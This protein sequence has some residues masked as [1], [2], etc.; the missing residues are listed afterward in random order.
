MNTKHIYDLTF[1][2]C[3]ALDQN[4][5]VVNM[6][7]VMSVISTL[8]GTTITKEQLEATRLAKYINH[9]RRRLTKDKHLA[10]RAKSLL[11]KWRKMVG[12]QQQQQ[13]IIETATTTSSAALPCISGLNTTLYQQ[14]RLRSQSISPAASSMHLDTMQQLSNSNSSQAIIAP[15]PASAIVE[16]MP[17][18][19]NVA[20]VSLASLSAGSTNVHVPINNKK[21]GEMELAKAESTPA[22]VVPT[23]DRKQLTSFENVLSGFGVTENSNIG[24]TS[25]KLNQL[26]QQRLVLPETFIIDQSSNSNS[27]TSLILPSNSGPAKDTPIVIDIQDSNSGSNLVTS[28]PTISIVSNRIPPTGFNKTNPFKLTSS[29]GMTISPSPSSSKPKKLKKEK[30]RKDKVDH[31]EAENVCELKNA[32]ALLDDTSSNHQRRNHPGGNVEKFPSFVNEEKSRLAYPEI[33]SLLDNSSMTSMFPPDGSTILAD[34]HKV[35][36][37]TSSHTSFNLST[38]DLTFTGKFKQGNSAPP[39]G[40]SNDIIGYNTNRPTVSPKIAIVNNFLQTVPTA[41]K[42][43]PFRDDG[44]NSN[45]S[46]SNSQTSQMDLID[47]VSSDKIL[48]AFQ[49]QRKQDNSNSQ[50]KSVG[51]INSGNPQ[52]FSSS[53]FSS[54]KLQPSSKME[55]TIFAGSNA[56]IALEKKLPRKRGRKKGSKGVDF[57]IAKETSLSSQ[58]LMTSLGSGSKKVKTTKELYAEMQNRK[59]GIM[60]TSSPTLAGWAA[61][62]NQ[63]QTSR[64]TS[65]CSEPS[66]QSPHTFDACSTNATMSTVATRSTPEKYLTNANAVEGET[67]SDTVTSEP[68]RDSSVIPKHIKRSLSIESNSNSQLTSS[69]KGNA[70][71]PF[72]T[73]MQSSDTSSQIAAIEKQ[74]LEILKKLPPVPN[75]T[76]TELKRTT[77]LIPCT[78]KITE[79]SPEKNNLQ[80]SAK[81]QKIEICAATG[82]LEQNNVKHDP[83]EQTDDKSIIKLDAVSRNVVIGG[84]TEL[85][86]NSPAT[87]PPPLARMKPKKSIFDLDFDDDDDPLHTLKAEAAAASLKKGIMQENLKIEVESESHINNLHFEQIQP[88][89]PVYNKMAIEQAASQTMREE[90]PMLLFPTYEVEEDPLCIAKQRFDIQT[91][92]ITKFHID[93]LHNCFIPNVNGNWDNSNNT[94]ARNMTLDKVTAAADAKTEYVITDGC[95][96][97]PRY[98]SL[99]MERIR[100]DLSHISFTRNS[101][102]KKTVTAMEQWYIIPFLGVARSLLT[103]NKR[104]SHNHKTCHKTKVTTLKISE[105]ENIGNAEP[106][107]KANKRTEEYKTDKQRICISV[108]RNDDRTDL[109]PDTEAITSKDICDESTNLDAR[110]SVIK[111]FDVETCAIVGKNNNNVTLKD[112]TIDVIGHGTDLFL[113]HSNELSESA[114]NGQNL[115]AIADHLGYSSKSAVKISLSP[116]TLSLSNNN[117]RQYS[118]ELGSASD[119]ISDTSCRPVR[120]L[121]H[122]N[123]LQ[124][125][126]KENDISSA[127]VEENISSRRSSISSNSSLLQTQQSINLKL[128]RQFQEQKLLDIS[129]ERKRRRKKF[130][131]RYSADNKDGDDIGPDNKQP[132]I[133]RIKIA[134]SGDVATQMQISGGSNVNSTD[135]ENED[136]SADTLHDGDGN[137]EIVVNDRALLVDGAGEDGESIKSAS[138]HVSTCNQFTLVSVGDEF[139]ANSA[140]NNYTDE[141]EVDYADY[142]DPDVDADVEF[143]EYEDGEDSTGDFHEVVTRDI[144][145]PSTGNNHILLTIKKTPSKTNSPSNSISTMSP[146]IINNNT[147]SSHALGI[148]MQPMICNTSVNTS[149]SVGGIVM[150]TSIVKNLE[151]E[152]STPPFEASVTLTSSVKEILSHNQVAMG[153]TNDMPNVGR[154]STK[155]SFEFDDTESLTSV[156]SLDFPQSAANYFHKKCRKYRRRRKIRK[157]D[158]GAMSSSKAIK[159]HRELFFPYELIISDHDDAKTSLLNIS[160]C[161]SSCVEDSEYDDNE[162]VTKDSNWGKK[163][164]YPLQTHSKIDI[165]LETDNIESWETRSDISVRQQRKRSSS[166]SSCSTYSSSIYELFMANQANS[167]KSCSGY[168]FTDHLIESAKI[169][170]KNYDED[171]VNELKKKDKIEVNEVTSEPSPTVNISNSNEQNSHATSDNADKNIEDNI[172]EELPLAN[173]WLLHSFNN[174]YYTVDKLDTQTHDE[175]MNNDDKDS[176]MIFDNVV[177]GPA[178]VDAAQQ[179]EQ[180]LLNKN[181]V[182]CY[183]NLYNKNSNNINFIR[184]YINDASL[185]THVNRNKQSASCNEVDQR[186]EENYLNNDEYDVNTDRCVSIDDTKSLIIGEDDNRNGINLASTQTENN[187]AYKADISFNMSCENYGKTAQEMLPY[188]EYRTGLRAVDEDVDDDDGNNCARIQQFKEWHQV[189][190]LRSYN[191][192]LLTVL[193]YVVLD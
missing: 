128:R 46:N 1:R 166:I 89:Q 36:L 109:I 168:D 3:Q 121:C 85:K 68:S 187:A 5:D 71:S 119:L 32:T 175:R 144:S 75:I 159:L 152:E 136:E 66:L 77:G 184:Y 143:N 21:L 99:V 33:L 130:N 178:V 139:D 185:E 81:N 22:S 18:I 115:L 137:E 97:A 87:S 35:N 83:L 8:E 53:V 7:A 72:M 160:S 10:L 169:K 111:P 15:I 24:I 153:I 82:V 27:E 186:Q 173:N 146:I 192:E 182:N 118:S 61:P 120:N 84:T 107:L 31:G 16:S 92:K 78:C 164:N 156:L 114:Q 110:L 62:Q 123:L 90:I 112:I 74:L 64:P 113:S 88:P 45:D 80:E 181:C 157:V 133:K 100:K 132:K 147:N 43:M 12:I 29:L 116:T 56:A 49:T 98:G 145:P 60:G 50:Q 163:E 140:D 125:A 47:V 17:R 134:I 101:I 105:Y 191:D 124:N 55:A 48:R 179:Q 58:M 51:V 96:V 57:V 104:A 41:L 161:S 176:H 11:K 79:I 38:S 190:Q 171:V 183:N 122:T 70:I 141:Q 65:S 150:N 151:V 9:L 19:T 67:T 162:F 102:S 94:I 30:K 76:A 129:T 14:Q 193:P 148:T 34:E 174:I 142:G 135:E 23:H 91:Q 117:Q 44:S 54:Q 127:N 26:G 154:R 93:A 73:D 52:T 40:Y 172:N 6:D 39:A 4:Y 86:P 126:I 177:V 170:I 69:A 103:N 149:N 158:K 59:F 63:Q 95:N 189:L 20:S 188:K 25:D 106:Q 13:Q 167:L 165:K 155:R 138:S 28:L 180:K 131:R 42:F 37:S 108:I 2:L